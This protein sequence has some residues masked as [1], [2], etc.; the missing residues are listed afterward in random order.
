MDGHESKENVYVSVAQ[1]ERYDER[2]ERRWKKLFLLRGG[3]MLDG[4]PLAK[5]SDGTIKLETANEEVIDSII[6]GTYTD[7]SDDE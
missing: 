7:G 2:A 3:V 5:G 1:L 4:E 6:A